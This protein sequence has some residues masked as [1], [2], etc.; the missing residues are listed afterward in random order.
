M[1]NI[2]HIHFGGYEGVDPGFLKRTG[3]TFFNIKINSERGWTISNVSLCKKDH[4][5]V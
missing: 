3:C 2:N 1:A 4:T 5:M